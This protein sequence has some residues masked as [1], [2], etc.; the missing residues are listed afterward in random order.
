[1]GSPPSHKPSREQG[2]P[3]CSRV[4]LLS[5]IAGSRCPKCRDGCSW[6]HSVDGAVV[7]RGIPAPAP[8]LRFPR[9]RAPELAGQ[10]TAHEPRRDTRR[11]GNGE[12]GLALALAAKLS[13][14][15]QRSFGARILHVAPQAVDA[16]EARPACALRRIQTFEAFDA[17]C[18]LREKGRGNGW[19]ALS[20][21]RR[22]RTPFRFAHRWA[23]GLPEHLERWRHEHHR[24]RRGRLRDPDRT[25]Q[26]PGCA[27]LGRERCGDR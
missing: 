15:T 6:F 20:Q 17:A 10:I 8:T 26:G 4:G 2:Q 25:N 11:V 27:G 14:L 7:V 16:F 22:S 5:S 24:R 13:S 23:V 1:M 12:K 19:A 3:R 9:G 18:I 21:Q